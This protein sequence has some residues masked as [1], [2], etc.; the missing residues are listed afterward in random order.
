MIGQQTR[1]PRVSPGQVLKVVGFGPRPLGFPWKFHLH[2]GVVS[3]LVCPLDAKPGIATVL[4]IVLGNDLQVMRARF[5]AHLP[6]SGHIRPG[7]HLDDDVSHALGVGGVQ[8]CFEAFQKLMLSLATETILPHRKQQPQ[9]GHPISGAK[10]ALTSARQ[11]VFPSEPLGSTDVA[12]GVSIPSTE[13]A[14]GGPKPRWRMGP[15]NV[16]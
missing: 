14:P 1:D 2:D 4:T 10:G 6:Q 15:S 9:R 8:V 13:A 11:I 5:Y 3:C 7:T 12:A 16:H